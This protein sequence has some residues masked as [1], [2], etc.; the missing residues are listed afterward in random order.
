MNIHLIVLDGKHAG[1]H[2]QLPL[3]QF[4]I[5]RDPHCHLR[6]ASSDVSRYHCAIAMNAGQVHVRDLK[7]RN[8]TFLNDRRVT[9]AVRAQHGD[10]LQVGPLRL[11]FH[12]RNQVSQLKAGRIGD[13]EL[14]WLMR[15]PSSAERAVLDPCACTNIFGRSGS[16]IASHDETDVSSGSQEAVGAIAGDYLRDY[17]RRSNS[18]RH[19]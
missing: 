2:I 19:S 11:E 16:S 7:S 15:N 3:T 13:G 8:G 14:S 17:L 6:P 1:R 9:G 12:V 4:V 5:G 10:I 18:R